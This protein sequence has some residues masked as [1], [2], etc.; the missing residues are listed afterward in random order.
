MEENKQNHFEAGYSAATGVLHIN[1]SSYVS[2]KGT[3]NLT[4][5]SGKSAFTE[6]LGKVADGDNTLDVRLPENLPAGIYIVNLGVDN[7]F[8]SKKIAIMK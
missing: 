8:A 4:D 3:I 7:N 2:G 6:D 1:L 5:L